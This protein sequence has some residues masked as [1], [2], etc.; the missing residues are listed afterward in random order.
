MEEKKTTRQYKRTLRS[1]VGTGMSALAG[2]SGR[3]YYILEHRDASKYHKAGESQKIIIDQIELGCNP[4]CQVRF[5]QDTWG[6]VSRRHAAIERDGNRWKLIHLSKVNSTFVNDRKIETECYL[7]NGDEIQL[8]AG[9]PRLGFIAPEGKQG[10]VSS[11]KLTERMELFRKQALKPYKRAIAAMAVVLVLAIGGLGTWNAL[12]HNDLN[13]LTTKSKDLIEKIKHAEERAEVNDGVIDSLNEELVAANIKI[14]DLTASMNKLKTRGGGGWV[15]PRP[16]PTPPAP[17]P[18]PGTDELNKCLGD[19]YYVI[20]VPCINGEPLIKHAWAGT[21]FLLDNGYFVTAQHMVHYDDFGIR[22]VE[23]KENPGQ[24]RPEIDP[25]SDETQLNAL[26]YASLLT[27]KLI[28]QSSNGDFEIEYSY[29]ENPFTCGKTKKISDSYKDSDGRFWNIFV[30]QYAGGDWAYT[31]VNKRGGLPFNGNYS[32][33]LPINTQLH[34]FGFP[35]RQGAKVQDKISPIYSQAVTAR[36]GLEDNGTIKTSNDNSDHGNSG[37]P[38]LAV[39]DGK[40]TV[41]GILSGAKP[42]SDSSHRK[43]VVIPIGAAF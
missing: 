19:V 41:V 30:H 13:E 29:N 27:I 34:I 1:T 21:G 28:C 23:D 2:G 33:N 12:L 37:G 17:G 16:V 7:E 31:K 3:R 5:D 6:I 39:K 8:A 24:K 4:D 9:G 22:L 18:N 42:G 15:R 40:Y 26:Y 43:G 20:A 25:N 14:G 35:S 32:K 36:A 38:V 11:I 10:L